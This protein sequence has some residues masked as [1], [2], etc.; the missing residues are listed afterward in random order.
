[1]STVL[2][3][4]AAWVALFDERD[5]DHRRAKSTLPRGDAGI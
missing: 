5:R 4:T 2:V 1:M 3:D